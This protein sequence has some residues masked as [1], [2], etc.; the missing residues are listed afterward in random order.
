MAKSSGAKPKPFRRA[1]LWLASLIALGLGSLAASF[2]VNTLQGRALELSVSDQLRRACAL[3]E[4]GGSAVTTIEVDDR[5]VAEGGRWP[6]PRPL[7]A[8]LL[9]ALGSLG[10]RLIVLDIEYAEPEEACVAYRWTAEGEEAYIL[11]RPDAR[12]EAALAAVGDVILP[13]SLYLPGRGGE[14]RGAAEVIAAPNPLPRFALDLAPQEAPGLY[15]AEGFNPMLP[16]IGEAAAGSGFTSIHKDLDQTVRRL[17]LLARGGDLVFPHL[18]LETAGTW[19]FGPDYRVRLEGRR[20]VVTSADGTESVSVPV[21]ERAQLALRWPR[22]LDAMSRISAV[23]LLKLV[24]AR[25]KLEGL[26]RQYRAI[27]DRAAALF[28]EGAY[29]A[30]RDRLAAAE[31]PEA[32]AAARTAL[33]QAEQDLA[34]ALLP[35]ATAEKAAEGIDTRRADAA[36]RY[37]P[38]LGT[39]HENQEV[40]RENIRR[41]GEATRAHVEGRVCILGLFATGISDIHK[42]PI[43][44]M[45]PGVT[46]YPAAVQTILSGVAFRSLPDWAAWLAAVGAAWAVALVTI[47]LPT[48]WGVAAVAAL[49]VALFTGAY[50]AAATAAWLLPVAGPVAA[51]VLA[52]GGVAAYRQLTEASSRRWITGVFKQYVSGDHVEQIVRQ[53]ER[54]RL[55][56]ER[57]EVTV[58]F[59]DIAGFTPLSESL[60]PERLVTLLN[61]YLGAMTDL[62]LEENAT[63]DKYEGDGIL[64]FFG[65]PVVMPDHARRAVRAALA[66]HDRLPELNRELTEEGLL[67]EGRR[68]AIRVGLST[69]P[70]IVG[71][72][73]SERRFDYTVMGD[74]VNLGGRLE[75]A[76]RWLRSHILVPEA[77]R[78]ACGDGIVFRPFGPARIRGKVETVGL[79][80]PLAMEP[81]SEETRA[82]AEGFRESI[83]AL[84]QGDAARARAVAADLRARYPEDGPLG[85]LLLR[86]EAEDVGRGPVEVVWDLGRPK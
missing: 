12:F 36:R 27:M 63:L 31:G 76:N 86:L 11:Q 78:A 37:L 32:T 45:Q 74:T 49:T 16:G 42:T 50:A 60:P 61:R 20:L 58:L 13:F 15:R 14:A 17:P 6:W 39:Y 67:P 34:M 10:P 1:R 71:N 64:A 70:A 59:S 52:F 84:A 4:S 51:V 25:R 53:P 2:M 82:L 55:G 19:R 62:V 85:V 29:A 24:K 8:E 9:E 79:Y 44:T 83:H 66:M 23:P 57:R 75:E 40:L 47:R 65:A 35:Y 30:A 26:E 43:H 3:S 69:G 72:F 68:L 80:E 77:T 48:G 21:D 81:A 54:L 41:Y 22:S 46:V 33:E 7:Q 18:V 28:P 5:S 38:F 73:G 56:G